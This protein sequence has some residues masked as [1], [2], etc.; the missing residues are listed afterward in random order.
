MAVKKA[1]STMA[2]SANLSA[3]TGE[4]KSSKKKKNGIA[5]KRVEINPMDQLTGSIDSIE[6]LRVLTEMK[7]GN[8][9]A[10]LPIDQVGISG[11]ICD[12]LNEIISLNERMM[13]EF[14]KA[15]NTIGKQGKLMQ[16]IEVPNAKGA[17]TPAW[18][19]STPSF[20]ILFIPLLKSLTLSALWLKATSRS[21]CR[22]RSAVTCCRENLHVLQKR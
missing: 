13:E 1:A 19:L 17:G 12:T 8:F 10:R 5:N 4:P 18:S 14:T 20:Q 15:G 2:D 22:R 16:R 6:L 7:N 21:R 11:K 9:S 3:E